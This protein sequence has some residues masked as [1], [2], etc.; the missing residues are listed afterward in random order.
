MAPMIRNINKESIAL[1]EARKL[2]IPVVALVDTNVDPALV[3][4]PIPSNDDAN[5][6]ISLFV[7]AVADALLEGQEIYQ[8]RALADKKDQA[9]K[10]KSEKAPIVNQ[11]P[12]EA[13]AASVG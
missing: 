4:F 7:N 12:M 6:T 2:S 8:A 5:R 1:A 9:E 11:E 3:K 10:A 13:S